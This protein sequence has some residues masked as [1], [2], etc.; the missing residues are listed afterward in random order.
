MQLNICLNKEAWRG[1]EN[2]KL[3]SDQVFLSD[4]VNLTSGGHASH[5]MDSTFQTNDTVRHLHQIKK[6]LNMT[7]LMA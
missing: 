7:K 6:N 3:D 5:A 4:A 2:L 1:H